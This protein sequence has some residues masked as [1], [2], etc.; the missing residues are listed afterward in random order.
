MR[1]RAKKAAGM[2]DNPTSLVLQI[3]VID[4]Q[5][6]T[7]KTNPTGPPKTLLKSNRTAFKHYV[8]KHEARESRAFLLSKH[9]LRKNKAYMHELSAILE[10]PKI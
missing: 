7:K 6:A 8:R 4:K 10:V 1:T 2:P 5:A 9:R 3:K